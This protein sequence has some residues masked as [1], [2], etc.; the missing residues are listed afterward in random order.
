MVFVSSQFS[1]FLRG[2]DEREDSYTS[3]IQQ[4]ERRVGSNGSKVDKS[5]IESE[6]SPVSLKKSISSDAW[7]KLVFCLIIDFIGDTS[8][9]LPGIGEAE[10]II[11]APL[12]AFA[13][14]RIFDSN[15][16]IFLEFVKEVLPGTDILPV[17]TIAWLLENVFDDTDLAKILKL[18]KS[19]QQGTE[20]R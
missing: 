19:H 18:G 9:L 8:F 10:D 17:A 6:V 5:L 13:L 20:K 12:G 15:F 11:A 14:S 3:S 16:I 4:R 7:L 2:T 1:R